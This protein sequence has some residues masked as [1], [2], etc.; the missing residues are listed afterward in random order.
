MKNFD[1]SKILDSK[2]SSSVLSLI[3]EIYEHKGKQNLFLVQKTDSL[4]SL[5]SIAKVQ[6]T[7]A[8]NRIEGIVTTEKRINEIMQEKTM[9]KTRDEEEIMGYRDV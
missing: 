4:E 8:S 6:S 2:F 5:V 7:E 1:Y 9:P 3:S